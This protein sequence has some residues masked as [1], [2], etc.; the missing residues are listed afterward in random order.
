VYLPAASCVLSG[1]TFTPCSTLGNNAQRRVLTLANAAQ[2]P[3]IAGVTTI[4]DGANASYNAFLASVNHRFA[5]NFTVLA[6]YTWSH[7]IADPVSLAIGGSYVRP[8]NRSF[9][10]GN[11]GGIDI[12]H[13][14]N[15]SAALQSPNFQGK[16]LRAVAT[17]W[18]L[19]PI[20][21]FRSGN[22]INVTS[23]VDSALTGV[24]GQRPNQVLEDVYCVDR[25]PNCWLNPKAFGVPATGTYGNLGTY[26][27]YGPNYFNVNVSVSRKF[28]L[29]ESHTLEVR[30]EAFN[31]Q[32]RVNFNVPTTAL[33]SANFGKITTDVNSAGS[34]NGS[35]RI[36][37][38]S[39]K[40]S[41]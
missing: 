3:S 7:C 25:G 35:P 40:Y 8:D 34:A 19:S 12:R 13:I 31:V 16:L 5:S 30:G 9:D 33:N 4:D 37:Q 38:V 6:N 36:I 17:G 22:P 10:R 18:Q 27:I 2:G 29:W 41:F 21:S 26:N 1:A 28:P 11:C 23:G 32:N 15:V 20:L 24:G 14:V 39:A